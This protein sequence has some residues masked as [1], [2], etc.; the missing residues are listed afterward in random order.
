V[1]RFYNA[2]QGR[3]TQVDP[4]G[5]SAASLEEPQT[6]NLYA[7]CGNDPINHIDPDGLFFKK[8]F[9][10]IGK[11]FKV[12]AIAVF[13]AGAILLG[14]GILAGILGAAKIGGAMLKAF[15]A[16]FGFFRAHPVIAGILN[17]SKK[18]WHRQ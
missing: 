13:V 4:I 6:L 17:R 15:S 7:Y 18:D 10:W 14:G 12:I 16:L 1:N 5:M 9:K 11:I 8:L 3:F 2:G